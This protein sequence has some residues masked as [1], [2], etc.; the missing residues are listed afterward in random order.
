M[1]MIYVMLFDF[2]KPIRW[3]IGCE[4]ILGSHIK[5]DSFINNQSQAFCFFNDR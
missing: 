1:A 2:Q 4:S 3:K 5:P